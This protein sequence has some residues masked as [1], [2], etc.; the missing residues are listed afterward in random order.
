MVVATTAVQDQW[1]GPQC[2]GAMP[3]WEAPGNLRTCFW[4]QCSG[5]MHLDRQFPSPQSWRAIDLGTT[6]G[7]PD[8]PGTPEYRPPRSPQRGAAESGGSCHGPGLANQEEWVPITDFPIARNLRGARLTAVAF[9]HNKERARSPRMIMLSTAPAKGSSVANARRRTTA[10]RWR[11][12]ES[13]GPRPGL[14]VFCPRP[15]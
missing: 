8:I 4:G 15:R 6:G 2:R 3:S 5:G 11:Q 9:I 10:H 13:P 7:T 14:F 12:V 1:L